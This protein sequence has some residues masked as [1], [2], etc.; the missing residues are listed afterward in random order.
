MECAFLF[1]IYSCGCLSFGQAF[2]KAFAVEGAK[3][4]SPSA[5][6]EIITPRRFF[7]PSFFFALWLSK[8][9]REDSP[10]IDE[11]SVVFR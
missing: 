2:L 3:S 6:G 5:D 7:L 9:K 10:R 4:S 8:K 11:S 1:L